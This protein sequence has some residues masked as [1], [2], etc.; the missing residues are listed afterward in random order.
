MTKQQTFFFNGFVRMLFQLKEFFKPF[1]FVIGKL[2]VGFVAFVLSLLFSFAV[3][4]LALELCVRDRIA[5]HPFYAF[6]AT[7]I[8]LMIICAGVLFAG[9]SLRR[10]YSQRA[11]T[12]ATS[13]TAQG[14]SRNISRILY[15]IRDIIGNIRV[16]LTPKTAR[17][18][19]QQTSTTGGQR[20]I[21]SN[22][23]SVAVMLIIQRKT[24]SKDKLASFK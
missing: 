19:F 18:P 2:F 8:V 13:G 5:I 21:I 10:N 22:P 7:S 9:R 15:G 4:L 23:K 3:L 20:R 1:I 6:I 16:Y 17:K 24:K 11:A 14:R 12:Q